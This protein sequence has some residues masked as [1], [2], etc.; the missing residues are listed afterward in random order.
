MD[1]YL[2]P[3]A[4]M[5]SDLSLAGI[6]GRW[7]RPLP[8]GADFPLYLDLGKP[9]KLTARVAWQRKL[10]NDAAEAGLHFT[11]VSK[12]AQAALKTYIKG[13]EQASRRTAPRVEDIIPV[14]ILLAEGEESFTT[15][16]SDLSRD[17]LQVTNDFALPTQG[18][19]KVLLP[20]SWDAP[21]E[22]N[23]SVRWQKKT[24]FGGVL[25]GLQFL[26]VSPEMG[27]LIDMYI[28]ALT[29]VRHN[30]EKELS[31]NGIE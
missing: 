23:A 19:F 9:I 12:R 5:P 20:L 3:S 2:V 31:V 4:V 16:A 1:G 15:I 21:L 18:T 7:E 17:G 10:P 11:K 27:N 8:E 25:A 26:D 29:E 28:L 24:A 13:L 6:R 22:L 14:E 30:L